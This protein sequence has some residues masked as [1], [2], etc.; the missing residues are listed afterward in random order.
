MNYLIKT[1]GIAV[2]ISAGLFLTATATAIARQ[3]NLQQEN[4]DPLNTTWFTNPAE[5]YEQSCALG[6]GRI[7]VMVFGGVEKEPIVLNESKGNFRTES[8][9]SIAK[10]ANVTGTS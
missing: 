7:G 5:A 2:I 6:N 10:E 1:S 8:D 3:A 4:L 9:S